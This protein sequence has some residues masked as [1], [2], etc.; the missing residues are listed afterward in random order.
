[1]VEAVVEADVAGGLGAAGGV[2][3]ATE[4]QATRMVSGTSRAARVRMTHAAYQ[5]PTAG[6]RGSAACS[7]G[8]SERKD[9]PTSRG[10]QD[11]HGEGDEKPTQ[12]NAVVERKPVI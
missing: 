11:W 7:P 8:A 4:E 10:G 1:V 6:A 2:V 12:V 5:V 9:L 3:V